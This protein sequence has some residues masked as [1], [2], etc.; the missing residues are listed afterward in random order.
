VPDRCTCGAQLPPDARFCHKCGKPQ[1]DYPGLEETESP[2]QEAP[3]IAAP[4]AQLPPEISF[5]NRMAVRAG[6]IAAIAAVILSVVPLPF[7]FLRLMPFLAGGFFAVFL[8]SRRS[9][10]ILSV[11][12]GAR[13][14]WITGILAFA[15]VGVIVTVSVIAILSDPDLLKQ[16]QNQLQSQLPPNDARSS[17]VIQALSDP[18]KLSAELLQSLLVLFVVLTALPIIGGALGAK[19]LEKEGS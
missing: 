17:S 10:Q 4:R 11:R 18:A 12:S 5:R 14:G 2:A 7:V 9:G 13:I 16:I 8:Y 15:I 6:L 19:L 1:Y 3:V